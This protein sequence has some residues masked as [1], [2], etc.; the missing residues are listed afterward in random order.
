MSRNPVRESPPNDG[1]LGCG[2]L[3]ILIIIVVVVLGALSSMGM[4]TDTWD[5]PGEPTPC[6][7]RK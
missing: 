4:D 3:I 2:G 6:E 1:T 5:C 7:E